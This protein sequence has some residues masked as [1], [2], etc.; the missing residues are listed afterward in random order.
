MISARIKSFSIAFRQT[1]KALKAKSSLESRKVSARAAICF[2]RLMIESKVATLS[3][4]LKTKS[5]TLGALVALKVVM[6]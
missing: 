5:P 6:I 2:A 4:W 1:H 3:A